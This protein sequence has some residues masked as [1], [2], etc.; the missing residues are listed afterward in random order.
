M[1]QFEDIESFCMGTNVIQRIYSNNA[2]EKFVFNSS[3]NGFEYVLD[4][5]F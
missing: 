5:S 3:S 1:E 2:K 4:M